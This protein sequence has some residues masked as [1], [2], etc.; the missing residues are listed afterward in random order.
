MKNLKTPSTVG[1]LE[2]IWEEVGEPPY[3]PGHQKIE[4]DNTTKFVM[5]IGALFAVIC[6][7]VASWL[8]LLCVLSLIYHI[9][10]C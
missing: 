4:L 9:R 3:E 1:E 2:L 5:G 6:M 7:I 10:G 8:L